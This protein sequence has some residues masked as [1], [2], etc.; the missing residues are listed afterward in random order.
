MTKKSY[1]DIK[2]RK[3]RERQIILGRWGTT[4]DLVGPCMFLASSASKYVTGI[5]LY[6]D[7][8]WLANG[9]VDI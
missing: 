1:K 5:D 6:V 4:D 8:G 9:L 3:A 2:K 7:G